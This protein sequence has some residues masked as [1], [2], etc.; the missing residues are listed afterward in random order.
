MITYQSVHI[1]SNSETLT[2]KLH[3]F[4]DAILR[5]HPHIIRIACALYEEKH[6]VLKTFIHSTREGHA[7]T[8]YQTTLSNVPSLK[9]LADNQECRVIENIQLEIKPDTEH[10]A[11]LLE[12]GYASS[13]TVPIYHHNRLVGFLFLDSDETNTFTEQ[14]QRQLLVKCNQI[15]DVVSCEVATAQLLVATASAIRNIAG[16]RDF[17]TGMHLT[18]MAEFSKLI[19]QHLPA[20]Y[21]L[22]DEIIE[23]IYLFA[24]L[25]DIGKI[26]IPDAIL[27]KNGKLTPEERKIIEMHVTKGVSIIDEILGNFGLLCLQPAQIMRNI[28]ACHHE[29]MNGSGYPNGLIGD[30][31]PIEARIVTVADIF[32]ALTHERPYK[33]PWSIPDALAEL[34]NMVAAGKLDEHCVNALATSMSEAR[35]I[36]KE[37]NDG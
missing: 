16:L 30:A 36:V 6:D 13:F 29:Y 21:Q 26:G 9:S 32:D 1:D 10:S 8:A 31:I 15:A 35:L 20:S 18:R 14:V 34:Q 4:H 24:P 2:A 37:Y 25:H 17:E 19:A 5:D 12:Q 33:K 28:I 27:L 3:E 7:I 23:H 22:S 11:W